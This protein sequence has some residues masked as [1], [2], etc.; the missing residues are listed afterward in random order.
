MP[1]IQRARWQR[2]G[3]ALDEEAVRMA[4]AAH[5][6]HSETNYEQLLGQGYARA[7]ARHDVRDTVEVVLAQ[8]SRPVQAPAEL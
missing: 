8:W 3:K 5:V 6:R 4:V 2:G 7:D 1:E